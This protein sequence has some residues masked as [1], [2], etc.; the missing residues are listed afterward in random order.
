MNVEKRLIGECPHGRNTSNIRHT[1]ACSE[2]AMLGNKELM[3]RDKVSFLSSRQITP[4][5]VM[6][7]HAWATKVRDEARC[8]IS[9]F[10]SELEK[11]VLKFLLR[12]TCPI[13]IVR[14][15]KP[16]RRPPAYLA[17]AFDAGRI[18]I[19]SL[20]GAKNVRASENSAMRRNRYVLENSGEHF[21]GSVASGGN[22]AKLL[23]EMNIDSPAGMKGKE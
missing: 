1:K 15:Q 12:G 21:F 4:E 9:G 10:Q 5:A 11:D 19:V 16:I 23:L 17:K 8:V 14:A 7:S 22:L 6:T 18:L 2:L 20:P 3:K 13:I